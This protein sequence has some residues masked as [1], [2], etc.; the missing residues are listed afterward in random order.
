[1]PA[2]KSSVILRHNQ[3]NKLLAR[4]AFK[5]GQVEVSSSC[6]CLMDDGISSLKMAKCFADPIGF[7]AHGYSYIGFETGPFVSATPYAWLTT[8]PF[9]NL[10]DE[11]MI[12]Q[13]DR[14]LRRSAL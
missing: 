4:W 6:I 8:S 5:A 3:L 2:A 10:S 12:V 7:R 9:G 14:I 1:M 13:L 11:E